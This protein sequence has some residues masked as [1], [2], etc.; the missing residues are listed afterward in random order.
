ME[1]HKISVTAMLQELLWSNF[2][3]F[4]TE[5]EGEEMRAKQR[6]LNDRGQVATE[7]DQSPMVQPNILFVIVLPKEAVDA[8]K[9]V[10]MTSNQRS[11]NF[12]AL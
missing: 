3:L 5:S 4:Q 7:G 9:I 8:I 11:L 1:I 2:N 12:S 10:S 6:G